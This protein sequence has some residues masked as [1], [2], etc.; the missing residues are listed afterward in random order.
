M[1]PKLSTLIV[2]CLFSICQ[3]LLLT[4]IFFFRAM[5]L[6]LCQIAALLL[7]PYYAQHQ[8]ASLL[9]EVTHSPSEV[10][11]SNVSIMHSPA[12]V[13]DSHVPVMDSPAPVMDS[14]APSTD[15][16]SP[17]PQPADWCKLL[18]QTF[19]NQCPAPVDDYMACCLCTQVWSER[20]GQMIPFLL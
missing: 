6:Q 10:V 5:K 13:M 14:P 1:V 12:P 15:I 7:T 8:F 19:S 9:A 2:L 20:D 3:Q 18:E 17:T 11:D 4:I 16:P